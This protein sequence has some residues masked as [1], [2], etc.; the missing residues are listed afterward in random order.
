MNGIMLSVAF[1]LFIIFTKHPF[2]SVE[3][4]FQEVYSS[5]YIPATIFF[6]SLAGPRLSIAGS[7]I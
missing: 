7:D 3:D 2:S 4:R 6:F 1:S 5:N